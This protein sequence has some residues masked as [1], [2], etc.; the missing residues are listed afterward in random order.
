MIVIT[1]LIGGL[2]LSATA[3]AGLLMFYQLNQA[4]NV[5]GS[6]AA[7]FAADAG[8]NAAL[9]CYQNAV[10]PLGVCSSVVTMCQTSLNL[11]NGARASSSIVFNPSDP[12]DC[13]D[14]KPVGYDVV[15]FGYAGNVE[16]VLQSHFS[17]R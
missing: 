6:G 3:I 14:G 2:F 9:N 11:A 10:A 5:Q 7:V 16:R 8:L 1:L 4:S 17:L 12:A 13:S 15:S